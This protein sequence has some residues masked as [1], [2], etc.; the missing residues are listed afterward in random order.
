MKQ[1]LTVLLRAGKLKTENIRGQSEVG[2]QGVG[3]CFLC[4]VR[5][6]VRF[7]AVQNLF[8]I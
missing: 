6:A 2:E 1:L 7:R 5:Q 4:F 8:L 3:C